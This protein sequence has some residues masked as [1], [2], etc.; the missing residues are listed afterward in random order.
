MSRGLEV[1]LGGL[2]KMLAGVTTTYQTPSLVLQYLVFLGVEV[3]VEW[4]REEKVLSRQRKPWQLQRAASALF[5][6]AVL[7]SPVSHQA[8]RSPWLSVRATCQRPDHGQDPRMV[9]G[10]NLVFLCPLKPSEKYRERV[11]RK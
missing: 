1:Y 6:A 5:S 10:Q 7:S 4:T 9:A 11:W 2:K 3:K 8:G